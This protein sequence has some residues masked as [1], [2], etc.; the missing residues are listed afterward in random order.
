[1][2]SARCFQCAGSARC[3]LR[4]LQSCAG[5]PAPIVE[6]RLEPDQ[7]LLQQG[8]ATQRVHVI[9]VGSV[10]LRRD[11]DLG[12]RR[13][14]AVLGRGHMLGLRA[15]V[16]HG[17]GAD[18]EAVAPT[19]VCEWPLEAIWPERTSSLQAGS[20][21]MR[22]AMR[23]TDAIADWATVARLPDAVARVTGAL[24]QLAKVQESPVLLLPGRDRLAE[25]CACAPETASRTLGELERQGAVRR[26]GRRRL[27]ILGFSLI[28]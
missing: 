21:L 28:N 2:T 5:L 17:A 25:L 12:S 22:A 9:K 20:V 14:V 13:A 6:R 26:L 16:D 4:T 3:P 10:L 7:P 19:R 27:E 1:M 15:A 23:L 11:T 8:Q 24:R 18:V